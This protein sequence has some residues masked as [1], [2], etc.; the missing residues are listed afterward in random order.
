M[1]AGKDTFKKQDRYRNEIMLK[2]PLRTT[3]QLLCQEMPITQTDYVRS[4]YEA[5][6]WTLCEGLEKLETFQEVDF[7]AV[8][9]GIK[10]IRYV[11]GSHTFY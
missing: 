6:K 8:L 2:M 4:T 5:R 1:A 11:K 7:A 10:C 9:I 3:R